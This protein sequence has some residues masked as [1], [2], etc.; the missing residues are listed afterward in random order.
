MSLNR[1]KEA[2]SS[3]VLRPASASVKGLAS[4]AIT[5]AH[6]CGVF[7]SVPVRSSAQDRQPLG[8]ACRWRDWGVLFIE[9]KYGVSGLDRLS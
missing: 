3:V 7:G 5:L 9:P 1:A 6:C 8:R 4:Y 2:L